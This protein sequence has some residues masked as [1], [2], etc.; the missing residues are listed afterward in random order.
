M[1][2]NVSSSEVPSEAITVMEVPDPSSEAQGRISS[3][4][5]KI[6]NSQTFHILLSIV[7]HMIPFL[8]TGLF[9]WAAKL[10]YLHYQTSEQSLAGLPVHLVIGNGIWGAFLGVLCVIALI[11]RKRFPISMGYALLCFAPFISFAVVQLFCDCNIFSY[12][13]IRFWMNLAIYFAVYLF[14][15]AVTKKIRIAL[16]AGSTLFLIY[17]YADYYVYLFRGSPFLPFDLL[18]AGTAMDVIDGYTFVFPIQLI[19]GT[20]LWLSLILASFTFRDDRTG[21]FKLRSTLLPRIGLAIG[22]AVFLVSMGTTQMFSNLEIYNDPWDMAGSRSNNGCLLNFCLNI[23]FMVVEKPDGYSPEAAQNIIDN[24]TVSSEPTSDIQAKNVIVI[25]NESLTDINV[26]GDA[27]LNED[28]LPFIHSL[29]EN[30]I[31]GNCYVSIFG[32]GTCNSEF[33]ALTG[34]SIA[35]LPMSSI[36]FQQYIEE[37]TSSL[38]SQ[39]GSLGY[40]TYAMHPYLGSAWQRDRVYPLLGFDEFWDFYSYEQPDMLRNLMSDEGDFQKLIQTYE[41]KEPGSDLMMFNVTIQNHGG[42][43]DPD[44][45][46]TIYPTDCQGQYP[47]TEQYLSL[48]KDTDE[49]FENLVTYFSQ[50]DE[51][52]IILMFGDHQPKIEDAFYEKL[53]GKPLDQLNQEETMKRYMT[54]YVL[55]ANYDIP[56]AEMDIGSQYLSTLLMDMAGVP[57]PDYNRFLKEMHET[58]PVFCRYGYYDQEGNLYSLEDENEYSELINNYQILQYNNMFDSKNRISSIFDMPSSD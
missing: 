24:L 43:N 42:F 45:P 51:P 39:F 52:T 11:R 26:L 2:Q 25:M 13:S 58:I 7:I 12:E 17:G 30:T 19:L 41:E 33:E 22:S 1:N 31:K 3:F 40:N 8:C 18:S 6:K 49:A 16:I 53:L 28:N 38:G 5:S 21:Y 29:T 46:V 27:H 9:V 54:P 37:E 48:V 47:N 14:L 57:L 23:Q 55:W 34:N 44:Y 36:A 10:I 4:L 35:F 56:E 15:Y 32:G 50:V 20:L